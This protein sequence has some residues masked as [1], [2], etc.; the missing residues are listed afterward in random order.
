MV[1]L[2]NWY[3]G[4]ITEGNT[5]R[6]CAASSPP[7][8][9][10]NYAVSSHVKGISGVVAGEDQVKIYQVPNHKSHLLAIYIICHLPLVFI[11]PTSQKNCLFICLIFRLPFSRQI[12][13]LLVFLFALSL[14]LNKI[15]KICVLVLPCAFYLL[16]SSLAKNL[17][18]YILIHLLIFSKDPIMMNQLLLSWVH[19][20]ISVKFCLKSW[21][22]KLWWSVKRRSL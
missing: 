11:S 7:L 17:F 2:L 19:L 20:I 21:I 13:C 10:N 22:W 5:Y 16:A 1:L 15:S 4:F 6:S 9:G 3:L 14:C 8:W 18:I 12:S